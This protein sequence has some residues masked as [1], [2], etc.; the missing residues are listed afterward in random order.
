MNNAQ[1]F[2]YETDDAP[3]YDAYAAQ[4]TK[5][6]KRDFSRFFLALVLFTLSSAAIVVLFELALLLGLGTKEAESLLNNIYVQW[7][8]SFLPMYAVGFPVLLLT[9]RGVNS[10]VRVKRKIGLE[11]LVTLFFISKALMF[12]GNLVGSTLSDSIAALLGKEITD[13]TSELIE[14]SPIWLIILIVVIIGPIVEELIFRRLMIDK[15]SKYGD[16]VAIVVSSVAFGLFHGNLYQFFYATLLGLV[17]GYIYAKSGN[18]KI[19]ILMHSVINL[20]GSVVVIPVIKASNRI[21]DAAIDLSEGLIEQDLLIEYFGD[22]LLIAS[23][24][25]VEYA[26]T[27]VGVYLLVRKWKECK[28]SDYGKV[29]SFKLP[30]E[31]VASSVIGNVGAIIFII[32]SL[33]NFVVNIFLT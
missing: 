10:S 30:R 20:L 26:L 25:V 15:L 5:C 21:V 23:Y 2:G 4:M 11:E 6:A 32:I 24:S 18:I 33:A 7:L 16:G 3:I 28:F 27:I 13:T 1:G 29:C 14:S 17:L 19:S 22:I 9:V 8:V 12:A 31:R